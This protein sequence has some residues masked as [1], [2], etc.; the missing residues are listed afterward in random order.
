MNNKIQRRLMT[1][2]FFG[3]A[4]AGIALGLVTGGLLGLTFTFIGAMSGLVSVIGV[5]ADCHY[6]S[7]TPAQQRRHDEDNQRFVSSYRRLRD[8]QP[9]IMR[10]VEPEA[11]RV[12]TIAP[13]RPSLWARFKV[14][15]KGE[16]VAQLEDIPMVRFK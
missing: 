7:L 13:A 16:K 14:R 4:V 3:L 6:S 10:P 11:L 1:A 2:G 9:A 12:Q 15:V 8:S 5:A